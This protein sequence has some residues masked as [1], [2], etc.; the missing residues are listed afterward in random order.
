MAEEIKKEPGTMPAPQY[1]DPFQE[2]RTEMDRLFDSFIGRGFG[3][4]PAVSGEGR[5]GAMMPTVDVRESDGQIVVEAELPGLDEK[6]LHVTLK[7]GVLRIQGE[8]KSER[9]EKKEDYHLTERSYGRY[10]RSFRLPDGI[11]EEKIAA[12]FKNG[13]L[14]ITIPKKPEAVQAEKKITIGQ[15]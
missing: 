4:F 14:Q 8:K 7:E 10:E 3:G 9:E 6:D 11:D 15:S 2:M 1:R 12:S 5:T 13:V